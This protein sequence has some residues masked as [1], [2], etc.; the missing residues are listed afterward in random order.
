MRKTEERFEQDVRAMAD[1]E[2]GGFYLSQF[3]DLFLKHFAYLPQR[4]SRSLKLILQDAGC[5]YKALEASENFDLFFQKVHTLSFFKKK[6]SKIAV[7]KA[8]KILF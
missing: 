7:R 6:S 2:Q 8:N 3:P 4:T 5:T 1:F